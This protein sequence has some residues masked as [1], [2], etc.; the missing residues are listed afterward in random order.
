MKDAVV[1]VLTYRRPREIS[2]ILPAL[3]AQLGT[4][5]EGWGARVLVIDNDPDGG[6]EETVDAVRRR[7]V[8]GED[9]GYRH[10]PT[11]GIAA[12]R[13]RALDTALAEDADV[14]IF[15]DDDER[16][17]EG[18]LA[19]LLAAHERY[20]GAGVAGPVESTFEAEPDAW[21]RAGRFFERRRPVSGT[22]LGLA[23]TNNLLLD[24]PTL[25]RT[26]LRF[27][28]AFGLV[29]G[30]DTLFTRSLVG[31]GGQLRWCAEAVVTDVVPAARVT[32]GWVIRRAYSSGNYWA[33][34]SPLVTRGTVTKLVVRVRDAGRGLV[35]IA[36]GAFRAVTGLLVGSLGRRAR[37]VRTMA[38][39]A[40]MVVGALGIR[41]QQYRRPAAN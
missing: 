21:V 10:E 2:A 26:G 19:A 33:F 35:R 22:L 39:G 28:N 41:Y 29:G 25:R 37:G 38:R 5:P 17:Q 27:D 13:N 12:A 34:T 4:V 15:I 6:A 14:L 24:L 1:A 18:W 23:A 8:G 11:P 7:L 30:S 16:P 40:G 20:R 3:V 31:A 36:G 32:R 9:I